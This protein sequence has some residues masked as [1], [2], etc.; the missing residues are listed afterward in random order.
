[1]AKVKHKEKAFII[2]AS[3]IF[4]G[5][6]SH[7]LHGRKFIPQCVTIEIENMYR[8]EA[9]LEEIAV[10]RDVIVTIP[11]NSS[12][13]FIKDHATKTGDMAELS[14]CDIMVLA[15]AYELQINSNSV[16]IISDDYDIQN[17]ADH[18]KIPY[19]GIYWRGI[20]HVHDYSWVCIGCGYKSKKQL[21]ICF[22]CGSPMKKVIHRKKKK[23]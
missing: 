7:K 15:L 13:A 5:I 4:N 17:L 11:E 21:D 1:M 14:E 18:L 22:E 3:A 8:G 6:L 10:K 20:T 19:K 23:R 12:I 2:D 16:E 9:L